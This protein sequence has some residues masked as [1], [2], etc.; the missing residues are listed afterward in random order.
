MPTQN[1]GLKTWRKC[2]RDYSGNDC[3]HS[4]TLSIFLKDDNLEPTDNSFALG[5][6]ILG[7]HLETPLSGLALTSGEGQ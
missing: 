6:R 1:S 2:T 3:D 4:V 7:Q 5:I